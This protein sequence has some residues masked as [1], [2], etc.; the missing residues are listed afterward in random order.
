MVDRRT[1]AVALG[2]APGGTWVLLGGT[3]WCAM[4]VVYIVMYVCKTN[5]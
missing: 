2:E 3:V 5:G 1:T 4:N